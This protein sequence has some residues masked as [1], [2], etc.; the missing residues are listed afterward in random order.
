MIIRYA[1]EIVE[2]HYVILKRVSGKS[3]NLNLFLS[4][5]MIDILKQRY[6]F[7]KV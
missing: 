4:P 5:M 7:F 3:L 2:K 1:Y 6:F